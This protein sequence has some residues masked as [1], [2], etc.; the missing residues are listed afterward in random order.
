[1]FHWQNLNDGRRPKCGGALRHG[2]AWWGERL[3]WEWAFLWGK[4][5]HLAFSRNKISLGLIFMSLHLRFSNH[6]SKEFRLAVH[7]GAIWLNVWHDPMGGWS[8]SDPFMQRTHCLHFVDLLLGK[9]KHTLV[10]G[11]SKIAL[12][13]MPEGC[14]H[15]V[16][17]F[18]TRTWKRPR[19]FSVIRDSCD[20]SIPGGIPFQGKGE[21]SWDCGDDGLW[22]INS[23]S[24]SVPKAVA[25]VVR[26][27][28]EERERYGNTAK[29]KR[30]LS[31][32]T[33]LNSAA[34]AQGAG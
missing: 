25:T 34:V 33:P 28:L 15:A 16:V 10:T 9:R 8:R 26:A 27:V 18:E 19:W 22:G 29:V 12:I 1:M 20:V 2:R 13:P 6:G 5:C 3:S 30:A 7:D 21:N 4:P 23:E 32:I 14:Y 24:H 31:E 11:E 17:T